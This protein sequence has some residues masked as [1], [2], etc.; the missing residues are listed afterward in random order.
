MKKRNQIEWWIPGGSLVYSGTPKTRLEWIRLTWRAYLAY[1][2]LM[3][4]VGR[5]VRI[6]YQEKAGQILLREEMG[7]GE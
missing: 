3:L 6:D 2:Q 5:L 4:I 1:W 7:D